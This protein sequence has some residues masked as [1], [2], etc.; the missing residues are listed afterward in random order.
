MRK[1]YGL[2]ES[3][4]NN[5]YRCE[6][7]DQAALNVGGYEQRCLDDGGVVEGLQCM[8][9]ILAGKEL[10]MAS[11]GF[12]LIY[13]QQGSKLWEDHIQSS[14]IQAQFIVNDTEDH[15]FFRN[16]AVEYEGR[17]ALVV[18][19][20]DAL[21]YVGR[22]LADQ[23]Q[24]E[25][26]SELNNV[27]TI[28][29]V[30]ALAL[31]DSIKIQRS[32][33]NASTLRLNILD[34]IRQGLAETFVPDYYDLLGFS[35]DYMMDLSKDLPTGSPGH[36]KILE[37]NLSSTIENLNDFINFNNEDDIYL[38]VQKVLQRLLKVTHS[39][40][41]YSNGLFTIYDPVTIAENNFIFAFVYST[42]G[43]YTSRPTINTQYA[44]GDGTRPCF[45]AFPI[46]THQPPQKYIQQT[47]HRNAFAFA[48]RPFTSQSTSTLSLSFESV[49]SNTDVL[50][51]NSVVSWASQSFVTPPK[52]QYAEINFRIYVDNSGG[53]YKHYNYQTQSWDN[54]GS[55]PFYEKVRCEVTDYQVVSATI[56]TF[57][58]D[59]SRA[60]KPPSIGDIVKVDILVGSVQWNWATGAV[61]NAL[62]TWG[63]I[64][65]F[66]KDLAPRTHTATNAKNTG[67]TETLE[68]TTIYGYNFATSSSNGVGTIWN[69]DI[70]A[71]S[72]VTLNDWAERQLAVYI[73]APKVA[74]A[75]LID[76]GD[77]YAILCPNFDDDSYVFNGGTFDAQ[78]EIWN[79]ELL[80]IAQDVVNVDTSELDYQ[81]EVD[82][83]DQQNNAVFRTIKQVEVIRESV[84]NL[85][86][87]LPY[88]VMRVS[89]DV[90]TIQPT[91]TTNFAPIINY[92][93][94][95]EELTWNIQELGKTQ[96]LTGGTHDLDVT[97]ELIICDTTAENI[98]INL[99][100]PATVKGR[101]YHF[102]K[103]V[104][105]HSVQLN[106][107]IDT[108]P[109]YSFNGKDD[110]KVIMSDG[111]EYW[112]VAYYHK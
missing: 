110:C 54:S 91:V 66:Q 45:Q 36:L 75:T 79:F 69:S 24:Y 38:D 96:S 30:D 17:F 99:P 74:Q 90:P 49:G 5:V 93:E 51:L 39:K 95:T 33:F 11:P 59:F 3:I 15:E 67:A 53:N 9:N 21:I 52:Q 25:R 108:L 37:F 22:L 64:S 68:E 13:N 41:I 46:H 98:I 85:P 63:A 104:P 6:I 48:I 32:W 40:L 71:A 81:D 105:S 87:S 73:D 111:V 8:L 14:K 23:M 78:S 34:F 76:D 42:T 29:A 44:V 10:P 102:K 88:D 7:W 101:K 106:G 60:F 77:Y 31:L 61:F 86:N 26:R 72:D 103:I 109:A 47:Y 35:D 4:N 1:Y 27:Y 94:T 56:A 97:A 57:T 19:K 2:T 12:T 92:D 50:S 82:I 84:G 89:P 58:V 16:I 43:V 18:Y 80:K 20:N 107:T 100:D 112:L 55:L 62:S 65:I 70:D 83:N 28:T